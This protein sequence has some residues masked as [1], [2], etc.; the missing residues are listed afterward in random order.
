METWAL[1]VTRIQHEAIDTK[2]IFLERRDGLPFVYQ[3]GQ[4][5][6]FLFSLRG[7]ELRRSYSLSTAPGIDPAPAVTIKRV[8]NGEVSRHLLD[9]LQVGDELISLPPMGRFTL[10]N[11]KGDAGKPGSAAEQVLFFIAAGSGIVPV[12]SLLKS[13]LATRPGWRILLLTQQHDDKRSPFSRTLHQLAADYPAERFRWVNLLSERDGRLNNQW[14]E[15]WIDLLLPGEGHLPG[16]SH[17]SAEGYANSL[18]YLCGPPAF[19]RMAQF[20]LRWKGISDAQIKKENFTVEFVP[21]PPLSIDASPKKIT[22][23]SGGQI[24]RYEVVWPATI[25]QAGLAH[26]IPLPYSCRGG[27][28]STCTARCLS[29][30]VK[31]SINEVLTEKDLQGGLVLTCVGYAVTDVELSFDAG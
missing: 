9:H 24:F 29:G 8:T 25:L 2:T 6:T 18:F 14:L 4:F 26:Q 21:P 1:R 22:I 12:F 30:Q 3:A 27:R 17:V 31:M 20:T 10:E 13:A 19:M 5:L 28:C 7:R 16:R 11:L 15:E 23:H